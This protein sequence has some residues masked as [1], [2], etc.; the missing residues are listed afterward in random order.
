MYSKCPKIFFFLEII[1]SQWLLKVWNFIR[2][3]RV[4][5]AWPQSLES[6]FPSWVPKVFPNHMWNGKHIVYRPFCKWCF[7]R[8][9]NA[10]LLT[11]S[12][13]SFSVCFYG[14]PNVWRPGKK[15]KSWMNE[16]MKW[17][18]IEFIFVFEN[19]L[20]IFQEKFKTV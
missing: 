1:W 6:N 18:N 10:D 12:R 19:Q 15:T 7:C 2:H 9:S 16:W 8:S 14:D 3:R 4:W 11:V 13:S 5:W 17:I 20:K